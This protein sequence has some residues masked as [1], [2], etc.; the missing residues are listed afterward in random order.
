MS[1]RRTL[2]GLITVN[3]NSNN[4]IIDSNRVAEDR[5]V[6]AVRGGDSEEECTGFFV[7]VRRGGAL[8]GDL[9]S[10]FLAVFC[11]CVGVSFY[12]H[13]TGSFIGAVRA[14][15]KGYLGVQESYVVLN[16]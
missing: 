2:H 11:E 7:G 3:R 5:S 8:E 1:I 6:V 14:L 16:F 9:F 4:L 10:F 15:S 12:V 13:H